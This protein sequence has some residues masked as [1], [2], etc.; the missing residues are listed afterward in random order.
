M[1]TYF[2]IEGVK[3]DLYFDDHSPPHFH[4]IYSE[5]E[6]LIEIETLSSYRGYLPANKRRRVI[7]WARKHQQLLMEIWNNNHSK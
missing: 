1:P 4:A 3:I 6:E 2:V 5:H 7:N